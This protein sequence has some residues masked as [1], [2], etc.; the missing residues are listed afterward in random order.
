MSAPEPGKVISIQWCPVCGQR[1]SARTVLRT[2][3]VEISAADEWHA[4]LLLK[5]L[6]Y[7]GYRVRIIEESLETDEDGMV[8]LSR[9][10]RRSGD[11]A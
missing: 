6:T 7:S 9:T 11:S 3:K 5:W 10:Y 8:S 2:F 4:D 1:V